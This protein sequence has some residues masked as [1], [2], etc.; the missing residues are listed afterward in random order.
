MKIL[1]FGEILWDVFG[2]TKTLGGAPLNFASHCAR[3]GAESYMISAVGN[4]E[5]GTA[6]LEA[7]R[8]NG[9]NT[10]YVAVDR[11]YPTGTCDVTLTNGMPQYDLVKGVAYDHIPPTAPRG[12]FDA[13][14]MGTL[15]M[16][17]SDSRRAFRFAARNVSCGEV[18]FDVNFRGS[19]YTRDLVTELLRDTTILKISSEEIGYFG[20]CDPV[21]QCMDLSEKYPNL[22]YILVTLGAEGAF[23]YDCTGSARRVLFSDKPQSKPLSTVGAGDSFAACFLVN[24]LSGREVG[25]CLD[26]AVMLSDYVVTQL[27]AVPDYD[28]AGYI[29]D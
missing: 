17:N 21:R 23:V 26:R 14:Y 5:N 12:S 9:V 20:R 22:K 29:G 6:A 19:F 25:V 11:R 2:E 24:L 16:R 28:P 4:D 8:E 15:A 3:L 13:L 27:G 7:L 10:E 18:L 1:S